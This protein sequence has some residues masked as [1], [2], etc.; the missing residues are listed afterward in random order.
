MSVNSG[1]PLPPPI[2]TQLNAINP[3]NLGIPYEQR[4][5]PGGIE[6]LHPTWAQTFQSFY[7]V[8][9][10]RGFPCEIEQANGVIGIK[11]GT[12]LLIGTGALAMTIV[13][14]VQGPM[15]GTPPQINGDD[16]KVLTIMSPSAF[17]HTV[18]GPANTFSNS[19]H[20]LTFSGTAGSYIR[21]L[22]YNGIWYTL[23]FNGVTIT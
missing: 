9:A 2:T 17:A 10:A 15:S 12:C 16:M 4:N 13:P 6:G 11:D 20:L 23:D 1:R 21:M 19:R 7:Q 5:Q 14:A 18:T 22:A 3:D 8:L